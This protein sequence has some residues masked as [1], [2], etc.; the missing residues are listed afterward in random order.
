VLMWP[1]SAKEFRSISF[2]KGTT[3]TILHEDSQSCVK[4]R[5]LDHTQPEVPICGNIQSASTATFNP[6]A[7]CLVIVGSGLKAMCHL[8]RE[9]T[10]HLQA[11]DVVFAGLDSTGPDRRWLELMLRKTGL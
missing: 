8:T 4:K 7:G 1:A 5:K 3:K 2:V 11:A 10:V 9:A 6:R